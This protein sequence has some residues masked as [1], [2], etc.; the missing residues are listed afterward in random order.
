VKVNGFFLLHG[1]PGE[2]FY[3][4]LRTSLSL[5]KGL[6]V[7]VPEMR[8]YLYGGKIV[9]NGLLKE[10]ITITLITDNMMGFFFYKGLVKKVYLFY[11]K[12]Q[13]NGLLAYPGATL[14]ALLSHHHK[15][16]LNVFR[17]KEGVPEV[18]LDRDSSTL[19]GKRILP[20][21]VKALRVEDEIVPWEMIQDPG[22]KIQDTG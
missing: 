4:H 12:R 15:V 16:K 21:G 22:Y 14:I 20:E 6:K 18:L 19:L 2:D 7:L 8:P 10:K 11:K 13:S 5:E 1:I 3:S 9:A 17:G